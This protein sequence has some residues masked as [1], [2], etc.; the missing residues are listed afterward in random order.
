M[1]GLNKRVD[2]LDNHLNKRMDGLDKRMDD[3][4]AEIRGINEFLR[5]KPTTEDEKGKDS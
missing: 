1:R 2:G 3:F 4:G 5:R